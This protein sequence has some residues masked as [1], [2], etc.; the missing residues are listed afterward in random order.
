MLVKVILSLINAVI[1][2]NISPWT[3]DADGYFVCSQNTFNAGLQFAAEQ[4]GAADK[5]S[6]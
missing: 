3:R 2:K 6:D 5:E 1:L 4:R